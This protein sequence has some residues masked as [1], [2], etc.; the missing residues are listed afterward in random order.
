MIDYLTLMLMGLVAGL[1]TAAWFFWKGVEHADSKGFAAPFG[2]IGALA[3]VTGL[4]MTLTWPIP[5]HWADLAF[6]ESFALFGAVLLATS[7]ALAKGWSIK[8]VAALALVAGLAA[9]T[10]GISLGLLGLTKMPMLTLASYLS[11][12]LGGVLTPLAL[13][14]PS[15]RAWEKIV[16]VVLLLSAILW[17]VTGFG[18]IYQHLADWSGKLT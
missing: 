9:I 16:A 15:R 2:V 1:L 13:L 8:P 11:A 5:Y 14:M 18:S 4:H 3:F 6:G 7:L 10:V 17:A 12:G